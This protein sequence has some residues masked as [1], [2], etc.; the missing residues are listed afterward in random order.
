M[1]MPKFNVGDRVYSTKWHTT[2]VVAE[3][4]D[5][6]AKATSLFVNLTDRPFVYVV[7]DDTS[8]ED[9][10]RDGLYFEEELKH[11]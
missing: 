3:P 5:E 10:G 1:S 11:A 9:P 4:S 6:D 2:G 7:H 8:P